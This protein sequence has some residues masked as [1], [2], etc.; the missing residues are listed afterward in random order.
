MKF[1][2]TVGNYVVLCSVHL[3][4]TRIEIILALDN[5]ALFLQT[6]K[7]WDKLQVQLTY[8]QKW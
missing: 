6:V 1:E 5:L 7:E 4:C 3:G 2:Q 8:S